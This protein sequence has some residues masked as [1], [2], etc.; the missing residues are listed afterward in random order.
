MLIGSDV[1]IF[2]G[3]YEI[4]SSGIINLASENFKIR[5]KNLTFD[6]YFLKDETGKAHYNG[7]SL[8]NTE[9]RFNVYNM[10]SGL[11]EGFYTPM[12]IGTLG[13]RRFFINFGG[14]TLDVD[15]NIRT[16]VYNLLLARND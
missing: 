12:E 15:A 1:Q 6:F 16:I 11:L 10:S 2:S 8:S 3:D 14:W 13:T 5:V 9:I 7:E 4:I